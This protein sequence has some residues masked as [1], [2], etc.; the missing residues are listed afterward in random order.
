MAG[1]RDAWALLLLAFTSGLKPTPVQPASTRRKVLQQI[2]IAFVAAPAAALAAPAVVAP[3]T[4][5]AAPRTVPANATATRA[6]NATA[7]EYFANQ[8]SSNAAAKA[9]HFLTALA[10][11]RR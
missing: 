9:R 6:V 5:V 4:P 2:G 7:A 11:F 3:P 8:L 1:F 10:A